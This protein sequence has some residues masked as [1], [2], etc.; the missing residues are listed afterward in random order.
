MGLQYMPTLTPLKPPQLIG[1]YGGPMERLGKKHRCGK[2]VA[3]LPVDT[4][5]ADRPGVH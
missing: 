5:V 3:Q 2:S 1:I 4:V